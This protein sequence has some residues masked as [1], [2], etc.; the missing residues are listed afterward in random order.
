MNINLDEYQSK[1][2]TDEY[3]PNKCVIVDA[4]PGAGKTFVT[5]C[6]AYTLVQ[7]DKLDPSSIVAL[8]FGNKAAKELKLRYAKMKPD[9]QKSIICSTIHSFGNY[10]TREYFNDKRTVLTEWKSIKLLRDIIESKEIDKLKDLPTAQLT[11]VASELYDNY[12]TSRI[13]EQNTKGVFS[14]W[15]DD[16]TSFSLIDALENEKKAKGYFDYC[17][18]L[19]VCYHNLLNDRATLAK[20]QDKFKVFFVD[21]A[22][23]LDPLQH[24]LIAL[25]AEK[26]YIV[27][28]GDR[29][30]TIYQFRNAA[31]KYFT[32]SHLSVQ[33]KTCVEYSLVYNYRST[34]NIVNL[35]NHVRTIARD[36]I[37]AK[38]NKPSVKGSVKIVCVKNQI[39]EGTKAARAILEY[40]DEGH[41]YKDI[42]IICRSNSYIK[43]IIEPAL[44]RENIPYQLMASK[45]GNKISERDLSLIYFNILSIACNEKDDISLY[46]LAT[47]I[48]GIGEATVNRI[49]NAV[50][51]GRNLDGRDWQKYETIQ[52][53][54]DDILKIGEHTTLEPYEILELIKGVC[55]KYLDYDKYFN[56]EWELYTI[57]NAITFWITYYK[58][59]GITNIKEIFNRIVS[60]V[61]SF[62]TEVE[63]DCIKIHT[64]HSSKGLE[65]P[66]TIVSGFNKGRDTQDTYNDEA[67]ILY[68]QLSRAID[69]MLVIDSYEYVTKDNRI[70]KPIKNKTFEALLNLIR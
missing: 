32:Y 5:L 34:T 46:E 7:D 9:G 38:P 63:D 27:Y 24:K 52:S 40:I 51:L 33:Y 62:D 10:I 19:Y 2:V 59:E 60:E 44:V 26:A 28:V 50:R 14:S 39:Q 57:T 6:K 21:E 18:M 47:Y 23:D 66:I 49:Q 61:Q 3:K 15:V 42:S 31:P 43:S 53:L 70:I 22:Q 29:M 68:V 13:T 48:K 69:T 17:D 35:C 37:L 45:S 1:V 65:F 56:N 8:A 54:R 25:L 12:N 64:V 20:I 41:S 4:V 55:F 16:K 11:Q 58:D 67:Y 36:K 30:Q